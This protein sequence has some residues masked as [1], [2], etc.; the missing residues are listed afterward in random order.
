MK[1]AEQWKSLTKILSVGLVL[2][3]CTSWFHLLYKL[4]RVEI[5][6]S[7]L[8]YIPIVLAA[9]FYGLPGGF[10]VA[11]FTALAYSIFISASNISYSR[12]ELFPG[13]ASFVLI[14]LLT[15]LLS[16]HLT[17]SK[18]Q[19]AEKVSH[20]T[21]V[22]EVGLAAT[23][24][25][26]LRDVLE[27]IMEKIV[28]ALSCEV[29]SILLLDRETNLLRIEASYGIDEKTA[30]TLKLEKG[31]RISGWVAQHGEPLLSNDV[32]KDPR[33]AKRSSEKYFTK[34]L[35]SVPLKARGEVIGVLNVNNKKDRKVFTETDLKLLSGLASQA[36]VAIQNA[37][38]YNRVNETYMNAIRA[39]A[40][41]IDEKDHYTRTHS[42]N[43][44]KYAVAIAQEM[45]RSKRELEEIH[46]AAQLHDLGKIGIHDSILNK[47]GKLTEDEWKEIKQHSLKSAKILEPLTFLNGVIDIIKQHHER[48]DGGGYPNGNHGQNIPLGAR[49]LAVADSYDAMTS[50]R[51]YREPMSKEEAIKELKKESGKQFDPDVV[52]AFLQLV[53]K[54]QI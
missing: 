40:R 53:K 25:L 24:T 6:Y 18:K 5:V 45:N 39:L 30:K 15:G 38:L 7:Y 36:S 51:P 3:F 44:T 47:P 50:E 27:V 28:Q 29:G 35:L 19:L 20:L 34:S 13:I 37:R 49:I 9:F 21:T 32:E 46:E 2:I 16:F 42:E 31:E 23:S 54:N 12:T 48:F 22:T 52:Q 33:F 14:G 11:G 43:V 26:H 1:N 4:G 17:K 41:A 10:T 8:Y